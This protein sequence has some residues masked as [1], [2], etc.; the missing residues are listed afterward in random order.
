MLQSSDQTLIY[1]V[2]T[3]E[4]A[5]VDGDNACT[6]VLICLL[7]NVACVQQPVYRLTVFRGRGLLSCSNASCPVKQEE[8]LP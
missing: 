2:S 7:V 5:L 1:F 8:N 6:H 3:G 4:T